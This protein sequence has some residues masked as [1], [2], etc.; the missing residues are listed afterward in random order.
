MHI[1]F[2]IFKKN[3]CFKKISKVEISSEVKKKKY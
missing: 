2:K 3:W 1:M